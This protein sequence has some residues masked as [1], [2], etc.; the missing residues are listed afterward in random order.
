MY[1]EGITDE[2]INIIKENKR[3]CKYFDIP[4]QHISNKIL[5]KMNRKT[6]KENIE[7]LLEKI[8][9]EIPEAVLRTN[10]IVGFPGE[11]KEDFEELQ[12]FVEK[13]KFD[14]LGVF[15]YSKEEGTPAAKLKEQIH[16]N[17]KK[18]RYNKIMKK[19][20][21]ISKQKLST[22]IGQTV[23]VLIENM[24]FDKKYYIGRTMQDV[25][26]ID[27]IVYIK[28]N[29]DKDVLNKFVTC[30]V[31]DISDYDLIAELI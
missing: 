26:E 13:V 23:E 6:S 18:S 7:K 24:S 19:Q 22:K 3:I 30:K 27:G 4:I 1:P 11:S 14:K 10:L 28:N 20:Q 29:F 8:K 31:I 2:L 17:T 15:T 5:K 16:H 25:P 9:K 21:E 12:E